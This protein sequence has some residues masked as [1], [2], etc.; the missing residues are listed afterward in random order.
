MDINVII[1]FLACIII[2]FIFGK[3][4]IIPLKSIVKL[5]IN[6]FLGGICIYIINIVGG[7]FG[8]HIG[9]NIITAMLVGFLGLPGAGLLILLKIILRIKKLF[10][11]KSVL[12]NI[13]KINFTI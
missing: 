1:T 7:S 2:L 5:I 4:F 3:I 13:Y 12:K 6:S 9:L 11:N 10:L 8:F